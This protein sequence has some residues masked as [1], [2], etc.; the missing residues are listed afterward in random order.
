MVGSIS[1]DGTFGLPVIPF[2]T[3]PKELS[4]TAGMV[5]KSCSKKNNDTTEIILFIL[6]FLL[7]SR[8]M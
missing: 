6:L 2:I 3:F 7:K 4:S 8:Q 5:K 1:V